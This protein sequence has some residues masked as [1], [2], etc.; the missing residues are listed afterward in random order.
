MWD[1]ENIVYWLEKLWDIEKWK[2]NNLST[3]YYYQAIVKI[4]EYNNN[5]YASM[6]YT[7][8]LMEKLSIK[9]LLLKYDNWDVLI[10]V[11]KLY[12]KLAVHYDWRYLLSL[13]NYYEEN[14]EIIWAYQVYLNAF[15]GN[16]EWSK[17]GF[18]MFLETSLTEYIRGEYLEYNLEMEKNNSFL[19]ESEEKYGKKIS[20]DEF[21]IKK[22]LLKR[23]IKNIGKNNEI[24]REDIATLFD[25]SLWDDFYFNFEYN[26]LSAYIEWYNDWLN[27]TD[28]FLYRILDNI[29]R[30]NWTNMEHL[31]IK[32][33]FYKIYKKNI[34]SQDDIDLIEKIVNLENDILEWGILEE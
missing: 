14:W 22:E 26:H 30:E 6:V 20:L 24:S 15:Q 8:K 17:E 32:K 4:I 2:N 1:L 12:E 7:A 13:A 5:D 28:I 9:E 25:M 27:N 18:L 16:I 29:F 19:N 11:D 10:E 34:L 31:D 3:Q 21:N 33:L 23:I